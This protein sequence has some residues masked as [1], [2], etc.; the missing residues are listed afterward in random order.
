MI[1]MSEQINEL[2][3]ALA[4]AQAEQTIAEIDSKN[5][6]FKNGYASLASVIKATV[7]AL[8]A[9]GIAVQ[10]HPTNDGQ[11]V[12]LTTMFLHSSGQFI[13]SDLSCAMGRKND[14]HA[15]GSTITYLRRYALQSC[16]A[17]CSGVEDDDGNGSVGLHQ[18]ARP[19]PKQK[20]PAF[21]SA[22]FAA[23]LAGIGLRYEEVATHAER[24]GWG[25]PSTW[26]QSGRDQLIDD[27]QSGKVSISD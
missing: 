6:H 25:R 15:L 4:K 14:A 21:N 5:S 10:Q 18:P 12:T 19:R 22:K 23:R 7:P 11:I 20:D 2:I 8:N 9:N 16:F 17:N 13:Q 24:E 1:K 27:L 3:K 26:T